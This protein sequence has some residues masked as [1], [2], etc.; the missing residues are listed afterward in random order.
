MVG[1]NTNITSMTA[2]RS[3]KGANS[4]LS[5]TIER[6]STG[7][8]INSA[9]DDSAGVAIVDRFSAQIR[10]LNQGVRNAGDAISL[11]Q[12]AEGTLKQTS[13]ALQRIRELAVQSANGS[14]SD[15]DRASIQAE[16]EQLMQQ[17]DNNFSRPFNGNS[18]FDGSFSGVKFQTGANEGDNIE[19]SISA[20]S[21]ATIGAAETAGLSSTYYGNGTDGDRGFATGSTGNTLS[22][23]DLVINGIVVG[24]SSGD[25]DTSSINF[26]DSSAISK[27]SAINNVSDE[28]GVTAVVNANKLEGTEVTTAAAV[29][30]TTLTINGV[31]MSIGMTGTTVEA[32]LTGVA[33]VINQNS[34]LTGV[35]AEVNQTDG[36]FR[37]DLVAEDGRNISITNGTAASTALGLTA[38]AGG[39]GATQTFAGTFTLISEGGAD[40]DIGSNTGNIDNAG[41]VEGTFSGNQAQVVS[42]AGY[43]QNTLSSDYELSAADLVIN[44]VVIGASQASSDTYSSVGK[45][46]SA[47]AKAAAINSVSE[48]SGVT[49]VVNDTKVYGSIGTSSA[50]NASFNVNGTNIA[51]TMTTNSTETLNNM[52]EAFNAKQGATGMTMESEGTQFTITGHEGQNIAFDSLTNMTL[53][54]MTL[55]RPGDSQAD[56]AFT[57]VGLG[58]SLGDSLADYFTS[59]ITLV[60][61]DQINID[62]NTTGIEETG[63]QVGDFG[64]QTSGQLLKDVDVSTIEGANDAITAIDNGL[65]AVNSQR[66]QL[67]AIQNRFESVL[68]TVSNEIQNLSSARSQIED[69]D[70]SSETAD[71]TK[72]QILVQAATSMLGQANSIPQNVLSLLG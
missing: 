53:S 57:R 32:D 47:I 21:T 6:L 5:S 10:G 14:N 16:V 42:N 27:V 26:A 49:A 18:I 8:R 35:V 3:L 46:S 52:V 15:A 54:G 22:T 34:G 69:V 30:A 45:A 28:T 66:S 41:L 23:G 68:S 20:M 33:E 55:K 65:A 51:F 60:S 24:A 61:G 62:S 70:F 12:T 64:A 37:I 31:D 63:F 29:D 38:V 13:S 36:G 67:G 17:V 56:I 50:G 25:S 40:I 2:Q 1:I 44:G 4:M 43:V 7:K 19:V 72:A 9:K 39:S 71:L 59:S 58:A 11:A 48:Q